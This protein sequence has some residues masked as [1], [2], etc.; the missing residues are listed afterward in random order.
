MYAQQEQ[1][2]LQHQTIAGKQFHITQCK[3]FVNFLYQCSYTDACICIRIAVPIFGKEFSTNEPNTAKFL[4]LELLL[5][6]NNEEKKVQVHLSTVD[7]SETLD[8]AMRSSY[9]KIH[10]ALFNLLSG[11]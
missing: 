2:Q 8:D 1:F 11:S 6:S 9:M 10:D 3:G 7:D 5:K 4:L